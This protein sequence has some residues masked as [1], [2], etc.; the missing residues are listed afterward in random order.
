MDVLALLRS[1][2][3]CLE[4]FRDL[5]RD[6]LIDCARKDEFSKIQLFQEKRDST[7]K[8]MDLYDRKVTEA[9]EFISARER[10]PELADAVRSELA[11][12]DAFVQEILALDLEI[13]SRI[14]DAKNRLLHEFAAS[15]KSKESLSKFKSKWIPSSGEEIDRKL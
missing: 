9:V 12:K 5:S 14:E 2:N 6:F 13:I 3:R 11:R 10:T 1:K 4:K 7:L 8:A 15:R